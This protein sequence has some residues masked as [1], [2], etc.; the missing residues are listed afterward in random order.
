MSDLRIVTPTVGRCDSV[1]FLRR[2]DDLVYVLSA[3]TNQ[4]CAFI[5][6]ATCIRILLSDAG[7][8]EAQGIQVRGEA[9]LLVSN[10]SGRPAGV[11]TCW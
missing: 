8:Q 7:C 4:H 3:L 2:S 5:R 9:P 10:V 6:N 1:V 11:G